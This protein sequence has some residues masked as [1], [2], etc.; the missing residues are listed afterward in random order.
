MCL[1][2]VLSNCM[3]LELNKVGPN[4]LAKLNFKSNRCTFDITL[5]FR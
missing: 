2:T 5:K 3:H 1:F 4:G